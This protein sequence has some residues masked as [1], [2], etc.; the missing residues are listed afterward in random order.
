[1][2]CG[3]TQDKD[4][5]EASLKAGIPVLSLSVGDSADFAFSDRRPTAIEESMGSS[6]QSGAPAGCD[7]VRLSSG[8]ALAF[9]G[10]FVVCELLSCF[11]CLR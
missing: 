5:S 8:D 3:V 6:S 11:V 2:C 7:V 1:M 10:M 4:E 9:G